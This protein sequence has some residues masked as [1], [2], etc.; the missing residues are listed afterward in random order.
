M[1]SVQHYNNTLAPTQCLELRSAHRVAKRHLINAAVTMACGDLASCHVL[2]LAC[3]RGGDLPKLLGCASYTGADTAHVALQELHRRAAEMGIRVTTYAID[4]AEA[5]TVPCNLALCNFAI[6]YFC[7]TRAHCAAL[8]GKVSACLVP[9]GVFCG[10]YQRNIGCVK[11]GDAFH[12]IVGDCVDAI[13]WR[14]PWNDIV[15]MA[16]KEGLALACHMPLRAIHEGSDYNIWG[17]I[18]IQQAPVQR[19]GTTRT[20]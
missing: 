19:S 17:F 1:S 9:G 5:P 14:V 16:L 18:M 8:L 3:G 20:R 6:H 2:D 11:W 7:D 10:T 12:A 15:S 13:E 4:A